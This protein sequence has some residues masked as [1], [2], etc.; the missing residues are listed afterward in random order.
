MENL[1]IEITGQQIKDCFELQVGKILKD[2]YGNPIR[3]ALEDAVKSKEGEIKKVVDEIIATA[4]NDPQFKDR[5]SQAVISR[6][7]ESALK[8]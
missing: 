6:M 5:I 1:T 4:I 2:D 3:R 8:K 7:V